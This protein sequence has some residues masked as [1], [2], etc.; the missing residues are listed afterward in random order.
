MVLIVGGLAVVF[1]TTIVSV[2]L[3]SLAV[4]LNTSVATIGW[5]STGYLLALGVTIP[6]AGWAQGRFGGKPVWMFALLVFLAGSIASS[7]AWNAGSLISFRVVQGVGGG[8]MLPLMATLVMQAAGGRA[9]GRTMSVV[10]L[11]AILGPV[12]G[13]VLGGL[14]LGSLDW[15]WLFWVN[16]PFCVVGFVLAWKLLPADRQST[17][18]RLDVLG[19]VLLAPGIVGVLYGL[20]KASSAGGFASV[21]VLVP[22]LIGASLL[23]VFAIYASRMGA[24][25][26]IDVRLFAHR[27]VASASALLFLSGAA[28][29]GAMLLLPLY[30]QDVRA[31]DALGAGLLLVPQGLGALLSRSPAGRLTDTIGARWV[32]L[33]GFSIVCV[34]TVPFALA[35]AQ[36]NPWLLMAALLLRGFGLGAVT[37]PLMTAAFVGLDRPDVPHASII[38]RIAQQV[39]G[40]FGVALLAVILDGALA[41][42]AGGVGSST[43]AFDQAFWWA[44]GFTG[45]A[46]LLCLALPGRPRTAGEPD[47]AV[48]AAAR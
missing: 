3:R 16:V 28:L 42:T 7:L 44:I 1:D 33:A 37:I 11:P 2:A 4:Q 41:H 29:Y 26:L 34:A 20:S 43:G 12:L 22:T 10:S 40:S 8:L 9:L 25:A 23:A 32:C 27:S 24:R 39:G 31:A 48:S 35:T 13:P 6:L 45:L 47:T 15:R 14:I 36:T 5:V 30:F 46:M 18:P 17:R 21:G 38:T 19:F